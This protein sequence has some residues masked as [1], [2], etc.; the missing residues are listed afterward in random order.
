MSH[1]VYCP[2]YSSDDADA[3]NHLVIGG[4]TGGWQHN[5]NSRPWKHTSS[6]RHSQNK[7]GVVFA[8]DQA[9]TE[10]KNRLVP[11]RPPPRC[12]TSAGNLLTVDSRLPPHNLFQKIRNRLC[13]RPRH[14]LFA[15]VAVAA[16]CGVIWVEKH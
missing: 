14:W 12:F 15:F 13:G 5:R 9:D 11:S 7:D 1:S 16:Y 8:Y 10:Q 3:F 2:H 6:D 4:R